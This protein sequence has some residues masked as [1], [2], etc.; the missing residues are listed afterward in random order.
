M[1][2]RSPARHVDVRLDPLRQTDEEDG[3]D[4]LEVDAAGGVLRGH[5]QRHLKV[6]VR[7]RLRVRFRFRVAR[8]ECSVVTS[9]VT[10]ADRLAKAAASS[11]RRPTC[12]I[13]EPSG[14]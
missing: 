7:F 8:A 3:V 14:G 6:R 12:V 4:P 5:E 9:R 13:R 1:V 11:C 2:R 10:A